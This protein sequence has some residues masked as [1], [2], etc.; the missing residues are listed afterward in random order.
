MIPYPNIDPVAFTL[1]PLK[2]HWYGLMYLLAFVI[3]WLLA[4]Y[5]I[6]YN[7]PGKWTAENV[8]DLIFYSAIGAVFGGRIGY[9]LFYAFSDLSAHPLSLF[10]IWE[11]GMSF[12]GGILGVVI[13][14]F[15]FSRKINKSLLEVLDFTAPLAPLGLAAGRLGNFINGELW[16][17]PTDLPWAMI[18]PSGGN[19]PRHPS[20]LYELIL[21]GLVL[22]TLVWWYSSK[23]RP[24]GAVSGVFLI[25]YAL[26]RIFVEFFRQPDYQ[27][28][29]LA[30]GWLTMGQILS[31]PMF[32][33][34]LYLWWTKR[35]KPI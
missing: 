30:F 1:G 26:S 14:L 21:E 19:I 10:K 17:Q 20:Q 24:L 12:H 6:A 3:A 18:F 25:G 8:S 2:V 11:G 31:I 35:C 4:R 16:G 33:I 23:P 15:I 28:G 29:Y 5:R 34:G 22:F 7:N 27:L 32:L 13:A 9:M